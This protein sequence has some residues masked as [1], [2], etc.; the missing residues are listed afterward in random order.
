VSWPDAMEFVSVDFMNTVGRI[1]NDHKFS[2]ELIKHHIMSIGHM[3]DRW[4]SY[5][6]QMINIDAN[7]IGIPVSRQTPRPFQNSPTD[8]AIPF[9][10]RS[11]LPPDEDKKWQKSSLV[12]E[13]LLFVD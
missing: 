7:R 5:I 6:A 12:K 3:S 10:T 8:F 1:A 11:L 13:S 9:S 2:H 4:K